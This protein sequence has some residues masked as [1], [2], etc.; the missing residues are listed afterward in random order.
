[1]EAL[2]I[3]NPNAG[4]SAEDEAQL[5]LRKNWAA[6]GSF[7][8]EDRPQALDLLGFERQLVFSTLSGTVVFDH[9]K[10]TRGEGHNDQPILGPISL[11]GGLQ[12]QHQAQKG[13]ESFA[14]HGILLGISH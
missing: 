5:L 8:K 7:I 4:G 11:R 1:M 9:L 3:Y 14:H 12:R 6:T 2:L 10:I 13:K